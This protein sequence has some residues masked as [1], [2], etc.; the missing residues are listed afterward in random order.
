MGVGHLRDSGFWGLELREFRVLG[1][2][3][4]GFRFT[5]LLIRTL[6]TLDLH[7]SFALTLNPT[8]LRVFSSGCGTLRREPF[9]SPSSWKKVP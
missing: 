9:A 3:F 2:G 8:T 6:T 7:L 1:L 4:W 5:V